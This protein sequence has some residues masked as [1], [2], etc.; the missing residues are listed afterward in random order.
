MRSK[1]RLLGLDGLSTR[2]ERLTIVM[3]ICRLNA[4]DCSARLRVL[5]QNSLPSLAL[6]GFNA[7]LPFL[8]DWLSILQGLRSR[9]EI[10]FSLLTKYHFFLLINGF[11]IVLAVS[12][13]SLARELADQPMKLI[14]KL[15]LSLPGAR[16]FFI[17][18]VILQG[19]G[20]MPLQLL[21]LAV[22]LPRWFYRLIWTRSPRGRYT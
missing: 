18:Y 21:Q 6:I 10:E 13:W 7:L 2:S 16:N 14:N 17:S 1:R 9:S 19:I 5:V 8:L 22:V 15:A 20:I 4:Y 3:G 11:F 12:T